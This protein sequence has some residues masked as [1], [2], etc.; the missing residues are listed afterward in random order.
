M[1]TCVLYSSTPLSRC[2]PVFEMLLRVLA[3]Y[4]SASRTWLLDHCHTQNCIAM[5]TTDGA[6][7]SSSSH[8]S[9]QERKELC[10]AL[11][12]AQESAIVQLLLEVCLPTEQDKKVI[13]YT[14]SSS[15]HP[16]PT[17]LSQTQ[18]LLGPHLSALRE[19]QCLVCS[20]LHQVTAA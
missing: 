18:S 15:T 16:H 8:M 20:Y 14:Q 4:T 9:M 11:T 1:T 5:A 17:P 12:A 13:S 3:A 2:A 19:I 10:V 7:T 6:T